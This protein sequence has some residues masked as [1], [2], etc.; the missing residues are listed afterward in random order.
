MAGTA[1]R[2]SPFCPTNAANGGR[3]RRAGGS[4]WRTS[5][6]A[7]CHHQITTRG[8]G[9]N[10]SGKSRGHCTARDICGGTRSPRRFGHVCGRSGCPQLAPWS[11]PDA[12]RPSPRVAGIS[13]HACC[14]RSASAGQ[15]RPSDGAIVEV[16]EFGR[17]SP[18]HDLAVTVGA[19]GADRLRPVAVNRYI[20]TVASDVTGMSGAE[21]EERLRD[22]GPRS[23]DDVS[24][25]RDGRRLDSREAVLAWLEHIGP[26]LDESRARRRTGEVTGDWLAELDRALDARRMAG[27]M[28][29][30]ASPRGKTNI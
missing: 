25:T 23:A 15:F 19:G 7:L 5:K 17:R 20:V 27:D 11:P 8:L 13:L 29:V 24:I 18:V 30:D 12:G 2:S 3:S 9:S 21:F 22:A 10:W 14:C 26:V 4:K 16:A 28:T 1:S 6:V